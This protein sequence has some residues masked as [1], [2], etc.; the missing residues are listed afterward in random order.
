MFRPFYVLLLLS[1]LIF[2]VFSEN[3]IT[4]L[5]SPFT[6]QDISYKTESFKPEQLPDS[7]LSGF[8]PYDG[9]K[10]DIKQND[11]KKMMTF[12]SEFTVDDD[13]LDM[14]ISLYLGPG[15]YPYR[16][17]INDINIMRNGAYNETYISHSY[18][19]FNIFIPQEIL[20]SG[21]EK[22]RLVMQIYPQFERTP[23]PPLTITSFEQGSRM[24]FYRNMLGV[25]LIRGASVLSVF[26]FLFFFIYAIIGKTKDFNYLF[27]SL[28]CLSFV[29]S[30]FEITLNY[31]STNEILIKIFSKVGFTWVA[32]VSVYFVT[33]Y[34]GI[35]KNN[36]YRKIIPC[37]LGL[38]LTLAFMTRSSKESLDLIY[39]PVTQFIFFPAILFNITILSLSVFKY[40]KRNSIPLLISFLVIVAASGHDIGY[41]A[42]NKLPYA[43]L[44][45][46]GFLTLVIFIFFTLAISQAS[47]SAKAQKNAEILDEKNNQQRKIIEK[48]KGVAETL[49]L[50][51]K[52]IEEKVSST[53]EKIEESADTNEV[54]TEQVFSR[55][56]QLKQVIVEMEERMRISAEKM[57]ASIKSQSEAVK[58]VSHTVNCLNEHI[59]EILQFAEDTKNTADELSNMAQNST[60]VIKESNASIIEVSEYGDFISDVLNS[61]EEITE[62]TS[63]LSINAA[64]EAARAGSSGNGFSVVAGEIRS[65]S[66]ASK[67]QLDS[68]FQKI[69]DMKNSISNSRELSGEVTGSLTNI[70]GNTKISTEKISSMTTKLNEQKQESASISQAVQ[71]LLNDT[72]IIRHLSE[73]NRTADT[74]VAKTMAD[75]RDLFLNL[76]EILSKQKD[77]SMELYQFMAHI[78]AVVDENLANVDILN[79]CINESI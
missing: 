27:F 23:L 51:S 77:E 33:E 39:G 58:E 42:R 54:I 46:Y 67:V 1:L 70:I 48:I 59:S 53:S 75:I 16:I 52:Q 32:L 66:S 17:Y 3:R 55:V 29:L 11:Q 62:K 8:K 76:T 69:E 47:T 41:I 64:I 78:Q 49:I 24:V 19:S 5:D 28:M 10:L 13:L 4:E 50:S 63:L 57:P 45:A 72:R 21:S 2:P 7:T 25:Y 79:S 71:S 12:V 35:L 60:K 65:L 15:D 22:N 43:Y 37:V 40:R 68:S 18:K 31:H 30:Y 14:D 73:E 56:S 61:I 74:A 44:T 26:L 38:I 34:T 36:I 6:L 20:H 9:G